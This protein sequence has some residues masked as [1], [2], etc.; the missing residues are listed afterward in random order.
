MPYADNTM[1]RCPSG[2]RGLT[3]L[4]AVF[5]ML[6]AS[7]AAA[8]DGQWQFGSSPSFS[9]GTY[10]TDTRTEVLHTPFTVRRLF[11]AGDLTVV[12]PLT[13]IWGDGGVTVVNGSPVRQQRLANADGRN[14]RTG[15]RTTA[16]P[17][18]TRECGIGDI[19][20]RGRYYLAD[21]RGW[22]PTIAL[23]AHVKA[24]T[25]SFERGLG[26]GKAD[27]GVAI[28]MSR[29]FGA[30]FMAMADG[31]YTVI[32]QPE[33]VAFNDSRWFDVGL[34][35]NFSN[36]VLNVSVFFEDYSSIIPGF[37]SARD[38]LAALSVTAPGGW[39]VQAA[40][41]F[42]LTDGAPDHAVT[43]GASRRF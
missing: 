43:F 27:E 8:A 13:C 36:G 3:A 26:T 30:G 1:M 42:G 31:G 24:P 21:E 37:A 6:F 14:T 28:E 41:M 17:E 38:V 18:P 9:S 40:G 4:L 39:R 35:R 16:P 29:T 5:L 10:G 33:G 19:V 23:R 25:A 7:A 12:L 22:M 2:G 34:G 15:G 32:G 20:V 11:D